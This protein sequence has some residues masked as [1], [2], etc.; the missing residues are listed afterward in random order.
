MSDSK[1]TTVGIDINGIPWD[2]SWEIVCMRYRGRVLRGKLAHYC[3]DW[4]GL[5]IEVGDEEMSC[6]TCPVDPTLGGNW[7]A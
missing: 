1:Q 6:C 3:D 4:D 7:S 5:P 2:A